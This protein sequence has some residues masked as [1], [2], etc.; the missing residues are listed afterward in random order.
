[1]NDYQDRRYILIAIFLVV[2]ITFILRLF[3][4]Q[5]IDDSYKLSANNLALKHVTL[6]PPRGLIYDRNNK[7]L[8]Y[9]EA[10]YNLMVIPLE[11]KGIDTNSFCK[12]INVTREEFDIRMRKIRKHSTRKASI[13]AENI[14]GEEWARIVESLYQ[15]PGVF[16]EQRTM[17]K[18]TSSIA[19][20]ALGYLN[21]VSPTILEQQPYYHLGD[22]I[23]ATGIEKQYEEDLRGI[24]GVA[25]KMRD[26]HMRIKGSYKEGK[27]DTLPKAGYQIKLTLDGKLQAYGEQLMQNKVGSIVAIEPSTGEIL[28]LV[29]S[30]GYDPNKLVGRGRTDYY[31]SISNN[32]SLSPWF[33][34]ALEAQYPPGSIFKMMQALVG[35]EEGVI[36]INSRFVCDKKPMNCHNHPPPTNL[37]KAIQFSCNPYFHDVMKLVVQQGESKSIFTDSP[38]GLAKWHKHVLS[39]GLGQKLNIDFPLIKAGNIPGVDYYNK[40]YGER[41]WAYSTIY[42]ISIG[43]GEVMVVPLQM[44]NFSAIIANRGYYYTPHLIKSIGENDSIPARY[45]VKNETT[46]SSEH[47]DVVVEA[48]R[49]VVEE[50]HGTARRA[51]IDNIEVCGKTGTVQ[52]P[53]GEDHSVF[54]A[55]APKVNPQISII[56][57]VENSGFG[58]T[59]AAPIA[60]LMMEQYLTGEITDT[61]KQK[62]ILVADFVH[63]INIK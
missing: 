38:L 37:Q 46:V 1:M 43:Q 39:F 25:I 4:I 49:R 42:S 58:G 48:M 10:A 35:L 47:Y 21:E 2:A 54:M 63:G 14:T 6:Y 34:R 23:G 45:L 52:N 9:N 44:A 11:I 41:R 17:R 55:F 40:I 33:N 5:V 62:R 20:H 7:L 53:H 27:Y 29:T 8:V 61:L 26:N 15:Y 18:Y 60:S 19:G 30:P 12:L 28:A 32:D 56:V 59:W 31:N 51:R 13:L 57:Y 22:Q 3:Y 24:R 36:T 50:D 16:G